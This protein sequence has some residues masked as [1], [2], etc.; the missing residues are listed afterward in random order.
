[1]KTTFHMNARIAPDVLWHNR[2]S[3]CHLKLKVFFLS[4]FVS[5][6]VAKNMI[7]IKINASPLQANHLRHAI[8]VW[9]SDDANALTF[10]LLSHFILLRSYD[11]MWLLKICAEFRESSRLIFGNPLRIRFENRFFC[12]ARFLKYSSFLCV[13][14]LYYL[15]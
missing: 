2:F 5:F 15:V 4:Q 1:M 6:Y 13:Y 3:E 14:E 10:R 11:F 8:F 9:V 12:V 7:T